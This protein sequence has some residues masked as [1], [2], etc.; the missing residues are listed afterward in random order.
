MAE[1]SREELA[2][3]VRE[4][5]RKV[6]ELEAD[7]V[8]EHSAS[9]LESIVRVVPDIVY[10][11]DVQGRFLYINDAV[12]RYGYEPDELVGRPILD[13]VHPED[14][15]K[16]VYKIN[17]R[18]TGTRSTRMLQVRLLCKDKTAVRFELN[19]AVSPMFLVNAEGIYAK[20]EREGYEFLCT[21]GVARDISARVDDSS[22]GDSA[23]LRAE[24]D[25]RRKVEEV[26]RMTQ[27]AVDRAGDGIF[28]FGAD[29]RI[30]YANQEI[31]RLLGYGREELLS[32]H[33]YEVG[34]KS[35]D[36]D[37]WGELW[38]EIVRG[39]SMKTVETTACARDGRIFPVEVVAN[40]LNFDGR[41]IVCSYLR[42]IT[43]R[44]RGEL[45]RSARQRVRD[46]VW[47]MRAVEDIEKV[48]QVVREELEAMGVGVQGCSIHVVDEGESPTVRSWR[49]DAGNVEWVRS[50]NVQAADCIVAMW[51]SGQPVFRSDIEEDANTEREYIASQFGRGV[52]S[53]LD[54]P[55]S[56]GLIGIN[57][58]KPNAF[59]EEDVES[60]QSIAVVLSDGFRRLEDLRGLEGRTRSA[61]LAAA[62]LAG[63][64]KREEVMGRVRDM[65][66]SMRTVE[67]MPVE[68][69]WIGALAEAGVD[70]SGMSLQFPGEQLGTYCLYGFLENSHSPDIPLDQHPWVGEAW[71]SGHY[72]EVDRA[73]IE[74]AG[75]TS[76]SMRSIVE[77]PFKGLSG[78]MAVSSEWRDSFAEEELR[79]VVLFAGLVAEGL[80]RLRDF[81]AVKASDA[82]LR[83]AQKMEAVGELAAGVA[84]NFNNLLQG[85]VGNIHLARMD[86]SGEA[87][88]MLDAAEETS[89][90]AA[91][92]VRQL[93]LFAQKDFLQQN[94]DT[95]LLD[96]ARKAVEIARGTFDRRIKITEEYLTSKLLVRG[97]AGHLQQIFL[98]LFINARDALDGRIDPQIRVRC[99][100]V[101]YGD[102]G[103]LARIEV[104][105]N[106]IGMDAQTR[107]RIF[108]P[109]FTTK[110][111]GKGTG[112]GLSTV[113][114]IAQQHGGWVDCRSAEGC[115]SSLI[116]YLPLAVSGVGDLDG[117]ALTARLLVV[118]D[119]E[120][121]RRT[122]QQVLEQRG[123]RVYACRLR[124]VVEVALREQP[125][126]VLL[127]LSTDGQSGR[128][129]LEEIRARGLK[130]KVLAFTGGWIGAERLT[131]VDG[132]VR[133]PL[134][135][136][137]LIRQVHKVLAN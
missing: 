62:E 27:F 33:A 103:L 75:H 66:I 100:Q 60:L 19:A 131:G 133:K 104:E 59:S 115:G 51:R 101:N 57:S 111:V 61:E 25:Q 5:R 89:M 114:G 28:W 109:F 74:S 47:K 50:D 23:Y 58:A 31:C 84:H 15:E 90:R 7:R 128:A 82:Q 34:G 55:F 8:K 30:V 113:Y 77:V 118:D 35:L 83:Q 67:D 119:D 124:D 42:D 106:G 22:E 88:S 65:I 18:R 136:N 102:L 2:R 72:V 20:G 112:L 87:K 117:E 93:M 129:A 94:R 12:R 14:K 79:T 38:A 6:A 26:L 29:G 70:V 9:M 36:L 125:D 92:M 134:P 108:D 53:I 73:R 16:A 78:S 10:R 44:K 127:D 46:E 68:G 126:L 107:E 3:Q 96:A 123:Y 95:D 32:M 110:P 120:T 81:A 80:Q 64:L 116:V 105:D 54:I 91:D 98:N 76:W 135:P 52:R 63:A 24:I 49:N 130:T 21:Q 13:I 97:D 99:E 69:F 137:E 132:V 39:P 41:E 17:D 37:Q 4:L 45:Q 85:I 48:I 56:H 43:A 121:V 122:T 86:T 40:Y 71:R 1:E 11:L